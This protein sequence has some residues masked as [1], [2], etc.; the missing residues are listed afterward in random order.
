[1]TQSSLKSS[2]FEKL[3]PCQPVI[4]KKLATVTKKIVLSLLAKVNKIILIPG[5]VT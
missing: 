2:I 3:V 1:M 5:I 4:L